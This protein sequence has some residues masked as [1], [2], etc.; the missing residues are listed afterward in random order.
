MDSIPIARWRT[1]CYLCQKSGVGACVSCDHEGCRRTFHIG[2][3]LRFGLHLHIGENEQSYTA[4][5]RT[6]S[7]KFMLSTRLWDAKSSM[8]RRSTLKKAREAGLETDFGKLMASLPHNLLGMSPKIVEA[9]YNYWL[10]K[11]A[12]WGHSLNQRLEAVYCQERTAK[13]LHNRKIVKSPPNIDELISIKRFRFEFEMSRLLVDMAWKRERLKKSNLGAMS[14]IFDLDLK[15]LGEELGLDSEE[16]GLTVGEDNTSLLD[17]L[18]YSTNEDMSVLDPG[19]LPNSPFSFSSSSPHLSSHSPHYPSPFRSSPP[20]SPSSPSPSKPSQSKKRSRE[21]GG[22][23]S[24]GGSSS[25]ASPGSKRK[26]LQVPKQDSVAARIRGKQDSG[27]RKRGGTPGSG[28]RRTRSPGGREIR[29]RSMGLVLGFD[30]SPSPS[31]K[32]RKTTPKKDSPVAHS[33]PSPRKSRTRSSSSSSSASSSRSRKCPKT[34]LANKQLHVPLFPPSPPPP[35]LPLSSSCPKCEKEFCHEKA[36]EAHLQNEHGEKN[37]AGERSRKRK[38]VGGKDQEGKKR[39]V[40]SG[41]RR[42]T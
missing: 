7:V 2:C 11:R 5:C 23:K 25:K 35:P 27:R 15:E 36:L 39:Q 19:E 34:P 18:F 13:K 4:F 31:S 14:E 41:K 16:L 33:T 22:G 8:T 10:R 26:I 12:D 21:E 37:E 17:S 1:V 38:R 42:K 20:L 28:G 3:A 6:H 24:G 40:K 32:K 30:K 9:V 29:T